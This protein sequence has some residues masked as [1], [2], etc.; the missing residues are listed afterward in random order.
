MKIGWGTGIFLFYSVFVI[1]LLLQLRKSLQYDHSLVVE[2]YYE[3]DLNYQKQYDK[4]SNS[5]ALRQRLTVKNKASEQH[6]LVQFPQGFKN[7]EG[8]ILFFRP[9]D[10]RQDFAVSVKPNASNIQ[11]IPSEKMLP[12]L[13]KVKVDWQAGESEFY[14]EISIVL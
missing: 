11:K 14:D 10:R 3:Q 12:G 8:E 13:W 9:N 6:I 1:S 4:K 7:L 5:E 2:N